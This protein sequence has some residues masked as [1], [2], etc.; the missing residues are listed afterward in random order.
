M[1]DNVKMDLKEIWCDMFYRYMWLNLW[2]MV[3]G[4]EQGDE[5]VSS[6]SDI[7]VLDYL[8]D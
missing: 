6:T 5:P 8:S 7:E 4:Y 1:K 3:G 2:F